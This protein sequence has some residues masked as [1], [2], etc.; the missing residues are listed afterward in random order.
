MQ[1]KE[2]EDIERTLLLEAIFLRYGYDFRNYSQASIARRVRQFLAKYGI[3]T[4]GELL[5]RITRESELFQSLLFEFSV[6]V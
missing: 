6:T 3:E 5:P 2:L 4:I 1:E